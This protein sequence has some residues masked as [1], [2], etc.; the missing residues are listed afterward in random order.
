VVA[1][2]LALIAPVCG[3]YEVGG[4]ALG[5]NEAAIKKAFPSAYC[6]P[7]EWRSDV[8]DRR[9]DDAKITYAGIRAR[10]TFYLLHDAVQA[11]TVRF[12]VNERDRVAAHFRSRWG[13]PSSEATQAILRKEKQKEPRKVYNVRWDKGNDHA[14]LIAQLERKRA[15]LEVWRGNFRDEIYRVR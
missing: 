15:T 11:F 13:A 9:C 1:A 7:L 8:A 14:L 2:A 10:V 4:I 3:A 12:S 6:K 5:S